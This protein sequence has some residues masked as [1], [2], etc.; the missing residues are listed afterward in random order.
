MVTKLGNNRGGREELIQEIG[1]FWVYW[2]AKRAR[3]CTDSSLCA[4]VGLISGNKGKNLQKILTSY[5]SRCMGEDATWYTSHLGQGVIPQAA[6]F[7]REGLAA[8]ETFR[9]FGDRL[10]PPFFTL[11]GV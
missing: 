6:P 11:I 4:P 5:E 7:L 2:R 1:E 8:L 9:G 3:A 10:Y